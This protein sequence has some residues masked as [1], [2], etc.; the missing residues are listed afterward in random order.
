MPRAQPGEF[1]QR[2]VELARQ[3]E[4]PI[5]TIVTDLG[6]PESCCGTQGPP[7]RQCRQRRLPIRT[8]PSRPN[9]VAT[10]PASTFPF[11][12]SEILLLPFPNSEDARLRANVMGHLDGGASQRYPALTLVQPGKAELAGSGG[13]I[14]RS[15]QETPPE[16]RQA[17]A[18][19]TYCSRRD[20]LGR[21]S[22]PRLALRPQL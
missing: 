20:L 13:A 6:I 2:A 16:S 17:E 21:Q 8:N 19:R 10:T 15:L 12:R 11:A 22:S 14:A 7:R 1:R 3:R 9:S 4:R 5:S 18:H